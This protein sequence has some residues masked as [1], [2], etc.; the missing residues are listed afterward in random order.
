VVEL[1]TAHG[2][3][4]SAWT[5][6]GLAVVSI[7][8]YLALVATT[9]RP[10]PWQRTVLWVAGSAAAGLAMS[11]PFAAAADGDFVAHMAVH[12]LLGMIAPL[13]LV[14]AGPVTLL[15]R[16]LPVGWARA[17][18]RLLRSRPA[19]FLTEPV[20]AAT[21][22]VGGLW[23]LYTTDLYPALHHRPALHLL[24]H[25]HVFVAGW[26]FTVAMISV[27][28]LP[29]RRGHLH[30]SVVLILAL[31]GHDVLAKF[32]YAHPPVGV[33]APAAETGAM[34]MYYGGDL[35]DLAIMVVLCAQWFRAR[36]RRPHHPLTSLPTGA[37]T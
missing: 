23:L 17:L 9:A 16:A 3:D 15:L 8:G 30:R 32:L 33:T 18:S 27:D 19:R 20:V 21:L 13:L 22:S 2:S 34:L 14:L 4:W 7:L 12:L 31:A 6:V 36:N 24:V 37:V 26:L 28:P 11:G 25:A 1:H 29:H 35:V 5:G 10:W